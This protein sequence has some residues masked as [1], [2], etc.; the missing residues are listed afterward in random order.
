MFFPAREAMEHIG[1]HAYISSRLSHHAY[2]ITSSIA[3]LPPLVE[4]GGTCS[5]VLRA[6]SPNNRCWPEERGLP[7]G[8]PQ[9][10]SARRGIVTSVP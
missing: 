5:G 2:L 1:Y 3:H 6:G 7:C 4:H 8:G 9:S 10:V